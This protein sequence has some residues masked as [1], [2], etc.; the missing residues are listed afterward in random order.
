MFDGF[1]DITRDLT[2]KAVR[3]KCLTCGGNLL[4]MGTDMELAEI[5]A[6]GD[7]F[8]VTNEPEYSHI[9]TDDGEE[10]VKY[11][12]RVCSTHTQRYVMICL[13]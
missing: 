8:A 4:A 12:L 2:G 5:L 13:H 9:N 11:F 1:R 6:A 10:I 3:F 7:S